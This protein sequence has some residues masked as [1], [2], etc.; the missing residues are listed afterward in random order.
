MTESAT[1]VAR[2]FRRLHD[3]GL[4]ILPNAW[5]AGSAR[6]IE[7]L[8]ARAI[9]T[10]SAAVAWSHGYP[11]GD[12]LPVPLLVATALAIA[13]VV[14]I[15]L[16]VDIEGGYSSDPAAVGEVV[17]QVVDAGTVGINLEDG[18]APPD[19]LCA[20]IEAAKRSAARL[21]IDLFV[22]A[23]S[24]VYLR[25]LVAADRRVSETLAR[26]E[27]YRAA[28]ADGLFV[29]GVSDATEIRAIATGQQLPL[30]VLAWGGLPAG[31]ELASLGVRRLSAGSSICQVV[32]GQIASLATNFLATGTSAPLME[33]SLGYADLN[34]LFAPR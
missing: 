24:D 20:K 15:P 2:H 13:R 18:T 17:A 14:R 31:P 19:L 34:A 4:L 12:R 21:G 16:S 6:M 5:D 27:R 10:S 9:A 32:Y 30:N 28:G 33:R 11:D 3:S 26:A 1:E 29:P 23:R 25:G 7:S 22:N 8:G